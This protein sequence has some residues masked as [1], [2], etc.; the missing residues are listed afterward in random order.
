MTLPLPA[1]ICSVGSK[2]LS[3]S[4]VISFLVFFSSVRAPFLAPFFFFLFLR[5]GGPTTGRGW[6]FVFWGRSITWPMDALTVKSRPRYLLIVFASLGPVMDL[7]KKTIEKR[8]HGED[9]SGRRKRKKK[10]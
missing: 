8:Q 1:M 3:S 10:K 5:P 2:I 6:P 7:P 9:P 4:S